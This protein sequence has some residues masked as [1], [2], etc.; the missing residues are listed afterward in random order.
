MKCMRCGVGIE[1]NQ[2]FCDRCLKDAEANP[3]KQGTPILLP[4]QEE[5][6]IAKRS[7]F[8]PLSSRPDD[9]IFQ[10]RYIIFWL[11]VAIVILSIALA[12]CI[13]LLMQSL[14]QWLSDLLTT[15]KIVQ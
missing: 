9:K 12:I 14:P 10:L 7:V 11:I 8:R 1:S 15:A 6:I 2:V 13:G 4:T 5:K 3:V